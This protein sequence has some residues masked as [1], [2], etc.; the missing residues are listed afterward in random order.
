MCDQQIQRTDSLINAQSRGIVLVIVVW[1]LA[2]LLVSIFLSKFCYPCI[3]K[4]LQV[5][6]TAA[7]IVY[8]VR[9]SSR[10]SPS[11]FNDALVI[12]T[13]ICALVSTVTIS[14]AVHSGLGEK[15]C[16]LT[17]EKIEHIQIEVFTSTALFVVAISMS[18]CSILL[19]IHKIARTSLQRLC[20][21]LVDALIL[22]WTVAVMACIVFQCEMPRPWEMWTGKCIPLVSLCFPFE[23]FPD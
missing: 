8:R 13:S 3:D 18:K 9:K 2:C 12:V 7:K 4:S 16:L 15:R 14:I 17:Y 22:V 5:F 11:F 23:H 21:L 1:F 10:S 6:C 19:L 20:I